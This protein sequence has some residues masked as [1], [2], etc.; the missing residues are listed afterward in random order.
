[1]PKSLKR[2]HLDPWQADPLQ[3]SIVQLDVAQD[4]QWLPAHFAIARLVSA[5]GVAA[6]R[7]FELVQ[8]L[9]QKGWKRPGPPLRLKP[10]RLRLHNTSVAIA[11]PCTVA[12]RTT[13]PKP[14][15]SRSM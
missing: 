15:V 4:E 9:V 2:E 3:E 8:A 12:Q 10:A 14:I 1:M 5:V 7:T 13:S 11:N 6:G